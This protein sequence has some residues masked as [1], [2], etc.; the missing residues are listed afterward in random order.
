MANTEKPTCFVIAPIGPK[1][2]DIRKRSDKVLKHVFKKALAK[3]YK[4]FRGD[5]IDQPGMITSQVLRAVQDSDLVLAD[6]TGHS[7]NVLYELAVR[8]AIEKPIIH[9]IEPKL[10]TIP[11]DI[12]G[13]RTIEFDL[14]DP[15]SVE[16]AVEQLKNHADAAKRGNWGQTPV[17][18][19]NIMH[20]SK[21][22]SPEMLLLKEVVAGIAE[23]RTRSGGL[24]ELQ[25]SNAGMPHLGSGGLVNLSSLAGSNLGPFYGEGGATVS[26]GTIFETPFVP[27]GTSETL[28]AQTAL[29][30]A[31]QP[32]QA[33]SPRPKRRK[34][35]H[36][37][38]QYS[39]ARKL[40]T[41]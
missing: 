9:V 14:T 16:S 35:A 13:F 23:L 24:T 17:K 18:L 7:P 28:A 32:D 3:K 33:P 20:R 31:S 5:E 22:D 25:F 8:H 19:A 4:V 27:G 21:E 15:D 30:N 6:L 26:R 10:S 12:A 11:F 29:R 38:K 34:F 2:S 36:A 1:D 39:K 41:I 37:S 40:T